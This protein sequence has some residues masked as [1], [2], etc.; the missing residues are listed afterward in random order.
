M[1]RMEDRA[2][3]RRF[4]EAGENFRM[5]RV[6]QTNAEEYA[7]IGYRLQVEM[8]QI[9]LFLNKANKKN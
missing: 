8:Q 5:Q 2:K 9:T 4:H 7:V 3:R 1:Y 6:R